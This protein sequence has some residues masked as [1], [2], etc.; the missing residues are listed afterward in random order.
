MKGLSRA[1]LMAMRA[2]AAAWPSREVVQQ[3]VGQIPWGHNVMLL[4]KLQDAGQRQ[5]YASKAIEHGWSRS[6]LVHQIE[7]RLIDRQAAAL[8][9]FR[10]TLPAAQSEAAQQLMKDPHLF[11][12]LG[13]GEAFDERELEDALVTQIQRFL[14]ELGRGFAFVG[15][16]YHIEV[17]GQDYYI[18]LLFYHLRLHCYFAIE[19]KIDEFKPE[20]VGKMQFYLAALD[21]QVKTEADGPS[22]GLILCR[23]SWPTHS[24][25]SMNSNRSC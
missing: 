21:G 17:G 16:Q 23:S 7:T 25:A 11:D 6:V 1:N 14:L 24:R 15:R 22:I 5:W 4:Q 9:N 10:T 18:D 19:L 12:F 8:T 3:L 13:L 20:C 2:F